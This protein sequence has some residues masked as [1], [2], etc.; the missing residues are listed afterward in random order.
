MTEIMEAFQKDKKLEINTC[1]P[2]YILDCL[3]IFSRSNKLMLLSLLH[4][5]HVV[6]LHLAF[7]KADSY[8]L[9]C[10]IFSAVY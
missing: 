7:G 8:F 10:L 9:C 6:L 2:M 4:R 5:V 1:I 3:L